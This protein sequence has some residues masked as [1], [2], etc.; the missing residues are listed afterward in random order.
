MKLVE[1]LVKLGDQVRKE[2]SGYPRGIDL[3]RRFANSLELPNKVRLRVETN[4]GITIFLSPMKIREIL[5]TNV[6]WSNPKKVKFAKEKLLLDCYS[7]NYRI[8]TSKKSR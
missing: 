8:F 3:L 6:P 2:I 5:V 1:K 7:G 4:K